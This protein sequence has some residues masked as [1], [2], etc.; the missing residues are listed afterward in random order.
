MNSCYRCNLDNGFVGS[1]NSK[2]HY[3][4]KSEEIAAVAAADLWCRHEQARWYLQRSQSSDWLCMCTEFARVVWPR[5]FVVAST[6]FCSYWINRDSVIFVNLWTNHLNIVRVAQQFKSIS[7]HILNQSARRFTL[8]HFSIAHR[9]RA[10]S[11]EITITFS[12]VIFIPIWHEKSTTPAN[13]GRFIFTKSHFCHCKWLPCK[14]VWGTFLLCC[15]RKE[16][17]VVDHNELSSQNEIN[18][19]FRLYLYR[20]FD[21]AASIY[22]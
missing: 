14:N 22:L 3:T 18:H 9:V 10:L 8:S 7:W 19:T 20:L 4:L 1:C 17:K 2:M 21:K 13:P 15:Q 11:L 5:E 12:Q 16:K 6:E